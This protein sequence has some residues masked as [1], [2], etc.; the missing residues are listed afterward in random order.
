MKF[1]IFNF[2]YLQYQ[3]IAI[4]KMLSPV[5]TGNDPRESRL[6]CLIRAPGKLYFTIHHLLESHLP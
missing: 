5:F 6:W 3:Y 2:F 1:G 4:Y